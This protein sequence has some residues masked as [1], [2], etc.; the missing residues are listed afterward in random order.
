MMSD[1]DRTE[2]YFS[3]FAYD[4]NDEL[5]KLR[6]GIWRDTEGSPVEARQMDPKL[7]FEIADEQ[8]IVSEVARC[9]EPMYVADCECPSGEHWIDGYQVRSAFLVPVD[10]G[11]P[12]PSDVMVLFSHELDGFDESEQGLTLAL[13][14][15]LTSIDD[16]ASGSDLRL[17]K[18]ENGLRRIALELSDLGVGEE[19]QASSYPRALVVLSPIS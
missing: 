5:L 17:Q 2:F 4:P 10:R 7:R 9:G 14:G 15:Y 8:A 1:L 16:G 3:Y 6:S 18:L 19:G 11:V 12:G 13:V